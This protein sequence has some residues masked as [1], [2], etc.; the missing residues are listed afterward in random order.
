MV[1]LASQE[2]SRNRAPVVL[3]KRESAMDMD[4]DDDENFDTSNN[5]DDL[6]TETPVSTKVYP[7]GQIP[8]EKPPFLLPWLAFC[9]FLS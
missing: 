9:G 2:P 6:S 8:L 3:M 4:D 5:N 1:Q 7:Q